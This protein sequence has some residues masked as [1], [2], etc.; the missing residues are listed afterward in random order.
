MVSRW[1]CVRSTDVKSKN[2]H[3]CSFVFSAS[4]EL[5]PFHTRW[6][7]IFVHPKRWQEFKN[8]RAAKMSK[9]YGFF[10]GR[11]NRYLWN[12]AIMWCSL[13]QASLYLCLVLPQ[14]FFIESLKV[15]VFTLKN[16]GRFIR[17]LRHLYANSQFWIAQAN[18]LI[19]LM[20]LVVYS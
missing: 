17:S 11:M 8:S 14:S 20:L 2:N 5:R 1:I 12:I 4:T 13:N 10:G 15:E 19:W 18:C 7:Q 16:C 3:A 6:R 9:F